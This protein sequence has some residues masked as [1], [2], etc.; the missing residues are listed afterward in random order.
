MAKKTDTKLSQKILEILKKNTKDPGIDIVGIR[1]KLGLKNGEQQH[2]DKRVRELYPYHLITRKKVGLKTFYKYEGLRPDKTWE[3]ENINK[4]LRAKIIIR[5]NGTCQKCGRTITDDKIKLHVDHKIPQSWGG[6]NAEENLE[7]ICST[8][9]EG[10]KDYFSTFE[11]ELMKKIVSKKSVH[12]RI[13]ELLNSKA[14][15]WVSADLIEFVANSIEVQTDWRKRL[16]ELRYLGATIK[17]RRIQDGRRSTSA[18]CLIRRVEVPNNISA[19]IR[20]LEKDRAKS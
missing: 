20:K 9:N 13:L 19:A 15:T 8:C 16:R 12:E 3:F 11:T 5:A 2:L 1:S 18:Y 4:T 17:S 10:K 7:A 6:S 14:G